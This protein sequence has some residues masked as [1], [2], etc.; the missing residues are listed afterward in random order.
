M[1]EEAPEIGE[2]HQ[3]LRVY[4]AHNRNRMLADLLILVAWIVATF[5]VFGFL[6]WPSWLLYIVIVAGVII[7]SRITPTWERPYRSPDLE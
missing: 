5:A 2:R 3:R 6:G 7:Y 1:A 4:L